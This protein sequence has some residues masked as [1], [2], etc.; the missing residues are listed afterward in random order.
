[1]QQAVYRR[2][3]QAA[4]GD[5]PGRFEQT[6]DLTNGAAGIVPL[7]RQDRLLDRGG[8]LGLAAINAQLGLQ[9]RDALSA[10]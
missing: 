3:R 5:E 4:L 8:D 1:V 7:G 6:Q 2:A 10:P 9:A